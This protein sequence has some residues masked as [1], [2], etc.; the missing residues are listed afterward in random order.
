MDTDH[1][2]EVCGSNKDAQ[3]LRA[4]EIRWAAPEHYA[5]PM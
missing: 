2:Q 3:E 1:F 5:I 4:P